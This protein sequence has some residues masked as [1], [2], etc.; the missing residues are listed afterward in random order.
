MINM[1]TEKITLKFEEDFDLDLIFDCGQCFRFDR[2][3]NGGYIGIAYE[4]PVYIEKNESFEL[5]T[6]L[7]VTAA[8]GQNP[9]LGK[10]L[11]GLEY[12]VESNLQVVNTTYSISGNNQ[13]ELRVVLKLGACIYQ[14]RS[15]EVIKDIAVNGE[16][17]K[18]KDN[19]FALKLYY[20]E[21]NEEIWDIAK[22]YNTGAKAIIE[23]NDM[24][25]NLEEDTA[26]VTTPCM[27]LIP[28]V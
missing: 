19:E 10:A 25:S 24:E 23:E 20:A 3:A 17:P 7:E 1:E 5:V 18:Q 11:K 15:V 2:D 28:I 21:A 27:L 4:T 8:F 9:N 12:S 22:K 16:A 26:K 6:T 14:I 13:V